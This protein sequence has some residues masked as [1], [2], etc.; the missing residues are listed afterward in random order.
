MSRVITCS[1][2]LQLNSLDNFTWAKFTWIILSIFRQ[3][4]LYLSK[5][6]CSRSQRCSGK[7]TGFEEGALTLSSNVPYLK[8]KPQKLIQELN[9]PDPAWL[10]RSEGTRNLWAGGEAG[11]RVHRNSLYCF[12]KFSV[13]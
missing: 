4:I 11:G 5:E 8:E 6:F 1:S 7:S 12:C 3:K 2:N 10:L 13:N 9:T